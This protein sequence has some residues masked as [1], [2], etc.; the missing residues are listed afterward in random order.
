MRFLLVDR[1]EAV[2]PGR[3]IRGSKHAAM[4]EDYFE[5]HFPEWPVVPGMLVLESLVQLAGWLE[6]VDSGFQR[7]VLLDRVRS[8]RYDAFAVPGDRI[9]LALERTATDDPERRAYRGTSQIQDKRAAR[10][11][12]ETRVVPLAE[13]IEPDTARRT[14]DRLRR[15]DPPGTA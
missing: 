11:E 9:D 12:F 13:L 14:F 6:A 5:W 3:A 4:S 10:V 15:S 1:I 7:W 2:E 8:A